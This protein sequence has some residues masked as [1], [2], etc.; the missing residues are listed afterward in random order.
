MYVEV[1]NSGSEILIIFIG[2][3]AQERQEVELG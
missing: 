2:F 1:E 3:M